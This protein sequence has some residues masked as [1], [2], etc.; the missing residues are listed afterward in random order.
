MPAAL[1]RL[2]KFKLLAEVALES[3]LAVIRRCFA[4]GLG[5]GI[6]L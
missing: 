2:A 4:V 5:L 3:A 1:A 6:S